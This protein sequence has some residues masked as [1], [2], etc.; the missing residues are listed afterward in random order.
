MSAK[1]KVARVFV[2][3]ASVGGAAMKL[4][5]TALNAIVTAGTLPKAADQKW[6]QLFTK[7]AVS[8]NIAREFAEVGNDQQG[9]TGVYLK[10]TKLKATVPLE[11]SE[12][13]NLMEFA[14]LDPNA[15]AGDDYGVYAENSGTE[16]TDGGLTYLIYDKGTDADNDSDIPDPTADTDA[17]IV[18]N[19]VVMS[20]VA[21][22]YDGDQDVFNL[23]LNALANTETGSAK[24]KKG[25]FGS[26]TFAV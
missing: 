24:G 12:F 14:K 23:E 26:F 16:L 5:A 19:G 17:Q 8:I 4:G 15:G 7:G 22:K 25:A 18:F 10:G 2:A 13:A 20:D 6:R 9:T 1:I 3:V 21:V 11:S